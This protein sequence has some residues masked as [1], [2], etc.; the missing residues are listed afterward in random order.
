MT[1]T[2]P[3]TRTI[4]PSQADSLSLRAAAIRLPTGNGA[5]TRPVISA[6]CPSPSCHRIDSVKNTL[7]KPA[8]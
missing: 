1:R 7:A 6:L 4:R 2:Q 5:M 8:K 3:E